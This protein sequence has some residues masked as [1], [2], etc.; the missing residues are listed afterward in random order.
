[1][2]PKERFTLVAAFLIAVATGIV[3]ASVHGWG[4]V[5]AAAMALLNA[6]AAQV[7]VRRALRRAYTAER[8]PGRQ[9]RPRAG[10]PRAG[11]S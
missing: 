2:T 11:S 3:A 8:D 6:A 10:W 1:M 9:H 4:L 7:P 5:A